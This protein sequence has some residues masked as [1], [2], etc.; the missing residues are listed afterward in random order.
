MEYWECPLIDNV[1]AAMKKGEQIA[2]VQDG[3]KEPDFSFDLAGLP[4]VDQ[5]SRQNQN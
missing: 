1:Y 5:E 2:F 4:I 3:E